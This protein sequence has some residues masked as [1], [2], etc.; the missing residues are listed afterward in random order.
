MSKETNKI[1]KNINIIKDTVG[2][3]GGW[4]LEENSIERLSYNE[5]VKLAN[6]IKKSSRLQELAKIIGHI[7]R[8]ALFPHYAKVYELS[9]E[10]YSVTMGDDLFR[11]HPIE[12][13]YLSHPNFQYDFYQRLINKRIL[14]YEFKEPNVKKKREGSIIVCIDTS[15]SMRGEREINAKAIALGL[16][17]I[18][19]YEKRNFIGILFGQRGK[20]RTFIF[21]QDNVEIIKINGSIIK[22][23]FFEGLFEFTVTFMGG[24]TDFETPLKTAL[25]FKEKLE[26]NDADLV[27]IT[28]DLCSLNNEFLQ[29]FNS[30]RK[31][32]NLRSYGVLIGQKFQKS[33][34]MKKFCDEVINYH[35]INDDAAKSVFEKVNEEA[36][37]E[38]AG[39]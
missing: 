30:I 16:L 22:L 29:S 25:N 36:N 33:D 14:Q 3:C 24:C 4:N 34:V 9:Q 39:S 5:K 21:N 38:V 20:A 13:N 28:D 37:E 35:E 12:M 27:F 32:K 11:M 15:L 31:R 19:R 7:R 18:A 23:G 8:L 2:I 1:V 6:K 17:E 26:F 10:V